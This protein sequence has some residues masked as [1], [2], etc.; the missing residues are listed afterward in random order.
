M[1]G[2]E[3]I[4]NQESGRDGEEGWMKRE[5][6]EEEPQIIAQLVTSYPFNVG[7]AVIGTFQSK[8]NGR[9]SVVRFSEERI[10]LDDLRQCS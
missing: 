4:I 1:R 9:S 3:Q 2:G 10:Y 5:G 8:V 6:E 7:E